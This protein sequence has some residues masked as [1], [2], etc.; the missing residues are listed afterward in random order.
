MDRLFGLDSVS[1]H[2]E[3]L[4]L[5]MTVYDPAELMVA[6]SVLKD[7]EIP[8]LCKDRGSGGMVKV[9]A[10]YSVMGTDVFVR[11]EHAEVA[12]ALTDN[13]ACEFVDQEED[14]D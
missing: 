6:Q 1:S 12:R 13:S 10:G 9:I 5:L 4:E 2:D 14:N 8:F 11:A 7:A 3:G